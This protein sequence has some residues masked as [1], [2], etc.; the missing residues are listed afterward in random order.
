MERGSA[1]DVVL[2]CGDDDT[3]KPFLVISKQTDMK[4]P[5]KKERQEEGRVCGRTSRNEVS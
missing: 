4:D 1:S 3:V 2:Q 5:N